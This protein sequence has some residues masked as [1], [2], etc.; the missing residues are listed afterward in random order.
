ILYRY[1]GYKGM[2]TTKSADIGT[3]PDAANTGSWAEAAVKWAVA[4]GL[5]TGAVKGGVTVLDPTGVAS[6]AQVATILYRFCKM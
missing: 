3:F 2:D 6:R 5:V 1:A 4:E